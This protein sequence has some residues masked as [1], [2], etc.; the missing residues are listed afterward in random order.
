MYL[1]V[2]NFVDN[3]FVAFFTGLYYCFNP[4]VLSR[5][6]SGH[7]PFL[8]G[9]GLL[10]LFYY[11]I[12]K[13]M[14]F[15]EESFSI[16][17]KEIFFSSVCLFIVGA[18]VPIHNWL[19]C[20]V[21]W[22]VV[23]LT[24]FIYIFINYADNKLF[25]IK[26]FIYTYFIVGVLSILLSAYWFLPFLKYYLSA[27]IN[28]VLTS[29]KT[30]W[31]HEN[32]V[33]VNVIRLMGYWW[34]PFSQEL[35]SP[36]GSF[37]D[38]IIYI[39]SLL[40]FII[41]LY[42]SIFIEKKT[43]FHWSFTVMA[44]VGIF[45]NMGSNFWG[46]SYSYFSFLGFFRDPDKYGALLSFSYAFI[47]AIFCDNLS[48]WVVGKFDFFD[49]KTDK[50]VRLVLIFILIFWIFLANKPV[51]TGAV[52][53]Y[54]T[55][56][57]VPEGYD[58]V[59]QWLSNDQTEYR[60]LWL[61]AEVYLEFNWSRGEFLGE[62]AYW[63]SGKPS[64]NPPMALGRES[65]PWSNYALRY[66][67]FMIRNNQTDV[68][69]QLLGLMNVRYVIF[70]SDVLSPDYGSEFLDVLNGSDLDL[71]SI[72]EPIYVY[73]NPHFLSLI[74]KV[75]KSWLISDGI[76]DLHRL[77]YVLSSFDDCTFLSVYDQEDL[78]EL[79]EQPSSVFFM[80][81][82]YD[83]VALAFAPHKYFYDASV[84]A[85]LSPE[86]DDWVSVNEYSPF[87]ISKS[88][89][90]GVITY[91]EDSVIEIPFKINASG[92]HQVSVRCEGG[93][94]L[95][96]AEI[97]NNIMLIRE[98]PAELSWVN[99]GSFY[100]NTGEHM[101]KILST[102]TPLGLAL[103]EVY[104][105]P[106]DSLR[107]LRNELTTIMSTSPFLLFGE[108]EDMLERSGSSAR[109]SSNEFSGDNG[110]ALSGVVELRNRLYIPDEGLYYLSV[111]GVR[112][113]EKGLTYNF[114]SDGGGQAS[115]SLTLG[116]ELDW[117]D[118][119]PIYLEKG[120]Y[121]LIFSSEGCEVDAFIFYRVV[122][123]WIVGSN[124]EDQRYSLLVDTPT[125]K[126]LRVYGEEPYYLVF[127]SSYSGQW[128]GWVDGEA[129]EIDR[130]SVFGMNIFVDGSESG[131]VVT[132]QYSLQNWV[133]IGCGV[134]IVSM[135]LS[136]GFLLLRSEKI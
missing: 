100:F 42:Y 2:H 102:R 119:D 82:E 60:V 126:R 50:A 130:N 1:F 41:L 136:I 23:G 73:E 88:D 106:S 80:R 53:E 96:T 52:S 19:L 26:Q 3:N 39:S 94:S 69:G 36:S 81:M 55:P 10:P 103:D 107:N 108:I 30:P 11:Y 51:Y 15:N 77:S 92:P 91:D 64:L 76:D 22:V 105:A 12:H 13:S 66:V 44:F 125:M 131:R 134:S 67:T 65:S 38:T 59:N 129:V 109:I 68:L 116:R 14:N 24:T 37:M 85:R 89:G 111:R 7:Y 47:M 120:S 87:D 133:W 93:D 6:F 56:F 115:G 128:Q 98:A 61:P 63:V 40:P 48:K 127:S 70:R 122:D 104:I 16:K 4:W 101:L 8:F 95:F 17:W 84:Y 123:D 110:V 121:R 79:V 33:F 114:I 25:R 43:V 46:E 86:P 124:P 113:P 27:S 112:A 18:I 9:Y 57:S 132:F 118:S 32:A 34:S 78:V 71:V 29:F 83:D 58:G 31:L 90:G 99:L 20:Y 28:V 54:L 45:L 72:D 62:P 49:L 21:S 135:V 5:V 97:D 35:Y 74:R 75:S 117:G